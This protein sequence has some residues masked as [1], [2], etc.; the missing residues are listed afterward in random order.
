LIDAAN[1][2]FGATQL[3]S[4]LTIDQAIDQAVTE[5]M[6]SS[7]FDASRI[8]GSDPDLDIGAEGDAALAEAGDSA[9]S[10]ALP[11]K[12]NWVDPADPPPA[13]EDPCEDI[14]QA[15][16]ELSNDPTNQAARDKVAK[17]MTTLA[18]SQTSRFSL[19]A[20]WID[21]AIRLKN[22]NF[23]V[24][25]RSIE[26]IWAE[27]LEICSVLQQLATRTGMTISDIMEHGRKGGHRKA[28]QKETVDK[29]VGVKKPKAPVTD[30]RM[31]NIFE[32]IEHGTFTKAD[33]L[34]GF[35]LDEGTILP[36]R[37]GAST[38]QRSQG[39]RP[40]AWDKYLLARQTAESF[41]TQQLKNPVLKAD[42]LKQLQAANKLATKYDWSAVIAKAGAGKAARKETVKLREHQASIHSKANKEYG[43]QLRRGV[44]KIK[45]QKRLI[46]KQHKA[47][48][49]K[50]K[51]AHKKLQEADSKNRKRESEGLPRKS[52]ASLEKAAKKATAAQN[53][54]QQKLDIADSNLLSMNQDMRDSDT[55][56]TKLK[57]DKQHLA[58]D[59]KMA[60]REMD[61][62]GA[63][64]RRE[65]M[66]DAVGKKLIQT[67]PILGKRKTD[68]SATLAKKLKTRTANLGEKPTK[69]SPVKNWKPTRSS[70]KIERIS[71]QEPENKRYYKPLGH[72]A[73]N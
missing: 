56:K 16:R 48:K 51:A 3:P 12:E 46:D 1:A 19:G 7:R 72:N 17:L 47:A 54:L 65:Q 68:S 9:D 66:S 4:G 8:V 23:A 14:L 40:A 28:Y 38:S 11:G 53:Q 22:G 33:P 15:L 71:V 52:T 20:S 34:A 31:T 26:G 59:L 6:G 67:K 39:N 69:L 21:K 49:R 73:R 27:A 10:G 42:Y 70:N 18:N 63:S 55:L 60:D 2:D 5:L 37:I 50:S 57:E 30:P 43:K 41:T 58:H 24:N 44:N 62:S 45:G 13:I 35:R 32:N 64:H 29:S 25:D 36:P 61:L